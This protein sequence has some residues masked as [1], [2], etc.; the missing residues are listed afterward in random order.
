M[1]YL[2]YSGFRRGSGRLVS[3]LCLCVPACLFYNVCCLYFSPSV[4]IS[5]TTRLRGFFF[6][7]YDL[8]SGLEF[9]FIFSPFV[10]G[11]RRITTF[12]GSA[13]WDIASY[14]IVATRHTALTGRSIRRRPSIVR[15]DRDGQSLTPA[16]L[17]AL[18][19]RDSRVLF[20][21]LA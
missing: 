7:F 16:R 14:V 17:G 15:P 18:T 9:V 5:V 19:T 6:I 12:L 21:S 3:C 10:Y 2:V 13:P 8:S 1:P 20:A 4:F 11:P